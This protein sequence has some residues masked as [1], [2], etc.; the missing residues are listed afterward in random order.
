M[1]IFKIYASPKSHKPAYLLIS[2]VFIL[3]ITGLVILASASSELSIRLG[4]SYYYLEHQIIFG[5]SFGLIGFL[6]AYF[7]PYKNYKAVSFAFLIFS[8]ILLALVFTKFGIASGGASRWV[9]IG[10]AA[11]QPAEIVKLAFVLY[12]A[13]WLSNAK[14]NRSV[15]F[16]TGFMPFILISGLWL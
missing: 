12:L 1:G 2:A 3:V 7:I 14:M 4:N 15:D 11:F 16:W 6:L 13:A 10:P 9:K 8:I 5:L